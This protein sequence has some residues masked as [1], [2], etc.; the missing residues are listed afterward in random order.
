MSEENNITKTS[1]TGTGPLY[2]VADLT[3]RPGG[4]VV[5][6]PSCWHAPQ[7]ETEYEYAPKGTLEECARLRAALQQIASFGGFEPMAGGIASAALA[8]GPQRSQT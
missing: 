1:S 5:F 2:V 3:H 8:S 7:T 6:I 4:D